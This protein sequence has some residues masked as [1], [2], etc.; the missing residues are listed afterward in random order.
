MTIANRA[1]KADAVVGADILLETLE[2]L[3]GQA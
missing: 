3:T 1:H 2:P